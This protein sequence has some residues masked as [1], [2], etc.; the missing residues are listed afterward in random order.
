MVEAK[1][2]LWLARIEREK[3]LAP[4]RLD[5]I[6]GAPERASAKKPLRQLT[7]PMADS[8]ADRDEAVVFARRVLNYLN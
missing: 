4:G 6:P 8:D 5:G 3:Q 1:T 2:L 7:Q